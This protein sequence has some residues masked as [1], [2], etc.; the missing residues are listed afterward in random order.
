MGGVSHT[1]CQSPSGPLGLDPAVAGTACCIVSALCYTAANI[2][3][4]KLAALEADEMWVTCI[5]EVVTVSV[6][7]PWLVMQTLRR[8]SVLPPPRLL[9][10]LVL[11][12]LGVQLA[13]NL[14]VQWAFG[15]VGIATTICAVFGVML[16]AS[17]AFGFA[18]LGERVSARSIT[19]IGLLIG[20]IV[21]LNLGVAMGDE[22]TTNRAEAAVAQ[23]GPSGD[24]QTPFGP[25]WV[26]LGVAAGC[27]GGLMYATLSTVIRSTAAARVPVTT[28]VF[29]I[30]GMGV[31][32][33]GG[34][35]AWRLGTETLIHTDPEQFTWMLA[36]G[37]CNLI[38]FLA[39]TKGLQLT[40][41]VH[42]NVLNASQVAMAAVAGV[43][44]FGEAVN[45]WLTFGISMTIVGV[46][47][48]GRPS[49]HD[50]EVTGA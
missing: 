4:R 35:S 34:L 25:G 39:I 8:R 6:I 42:A 50:Q 13:G 5:K 3:L 47:L 31:L 12:G 24:A 9:L 7:G 21:M 28:I 27:L 10:A 38:A 19:A 16:T 29:V 2:C 46:I 49:D 17:A 26:F 30:T 43:L 44:L 15:V 1:T 33:L 14:S 20:S 36:A 11:T 32:S 41:I 22:S 18:F 40:T 45:P 48:I 37:T 23:A